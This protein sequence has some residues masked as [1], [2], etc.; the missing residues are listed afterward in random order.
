M[1]VKAKKIAFYGA[2]AFGIALVVF[3]LMLW[4]NIGILNIFGYF[5]HSDMYKDSIVLFYGNN[6]PYCI[7]VDTYLTNNNVAKKVV[8]TRLNVIGNDYN[9]SELADKVQNCGLDI[10]KIGIPFLWDGPDKKCY[11]GYVDI[12]NFFARKMA[13]RAK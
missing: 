12:I 4:A 9:R 1:K 10:H 5:S 6:C 8:Y 11:I 2:M 7:K 3:A 13:A